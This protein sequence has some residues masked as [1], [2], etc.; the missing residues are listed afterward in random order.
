MPEIKEKKEF[1]RRPQPTFSI[2]DFY[3]YETPGGARLNLSAWG[4]R[5]I[6]TFSTWSAETKE[7]KEEKVWLN[8]DL[9]LVIDS[10]LKDIVMNRVDCWKSKTPYPSFSVVLNNAY[11]DKEGVT[12]ETGKLFFRT[13][14]VNE[15]GRTTNRVQ[16]AI[17]SSKGGSFHLTFG[18]KLINTIIAASPDLIAKIDPIDTALYRFAMTV[19]KTSTSM[20]Q[21]AV[22]T[23]LA[24]L[25]INGG[26]NDNQSYQSN[27]NNNRGNGGGYNNNNRGY[28]NNRGNN[29]NRGG[30]R[31]QTDVQKNDAELIF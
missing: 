17:E 14:E 8:Q 3:N 20:V 27:N 13:V 16:I 25:I 2:A 19:N 29:N 7:R 21:Y 5:I 15:D 18:N 30:G 28:D 9:L 6:M 26:N 22:G 4:D 10:V 11:N 24:E 31:F 23:K 1:Q 12:H